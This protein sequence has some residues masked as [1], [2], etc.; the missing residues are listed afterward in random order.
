MRERREAINRSLGNHPNLAFDLTLRAE[1]LIRLGRGAEAEEALMEIDQRAAEGVGAYAGRRTRVAMLRAM[2]AATEGRHADTL[3]FA[4]L[5]Q[6]PGRSDGTT[7]F[8]R[9]LE[10]YTM[11]ATLRTRH[12]AAVSLTPSVASAASREISYWLA[13]AFLARADYQRAYDTAKA[14]RSAPGAQGDIELAWRMDA[15][16]ADAASRL[17]NIAE[18]SATMAAESDRN[19]AQ[20]AAAWGNAVKTY[21]ERSDLRG[22]RRGKQD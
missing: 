15:I 14:T 13:R 20:L 3:R 22:L 19:V 18:L 16:A 17:T 6:E 2:R 12:A 8:A 7:R 21:L 4:K 11:A 9:A 10:E 5:A 1:L